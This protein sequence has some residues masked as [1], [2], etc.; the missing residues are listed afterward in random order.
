MTASNRKDGEPT[1]GRRLAARLLAEGRPARVL[2]PPSETAGWPPGT[3]IVVGDVARPG[4]TPAAFAGIERLFLAGALPATVREAVTLARAGGV[5]RIA[6]LSSHGPDMEIE[7]E[8]E[9][10]YW[11]AIEVVVE[12]SGAW[13][14][15]LQ[16]SPI[17]NQTLRAGYPRSRAS[18]AAAIRAGEVIR[19]PYPDSAVPFIDEDDLAAI[20]VAAL[21]EDGHAGQTLTVHGEPISLREQL[22]LIGQALGRDI[23]FA[24]Q[25]PEQAAE[26]ARRQGMAEQ[27]IEQWL[28][29]KATWAA[30]LDDPDY[31]RW[32]DLGITTVTRV[33]GRPPRSYA[34]WLADQVEVF[35]SGR[36]A[37]RGGRR[38]EAAG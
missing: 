11:L 22:R 3:E 9:S 24:E 6:V 21:F 18:L 34:D 20:A 15:H 5:A 10:W 26:H 28:A 4:E 7:F 19:E 36:P 13:W 35:G 30:T 2:A 37:N 12:R 27:E 38:V 17:M 14:T 32:L 23:P 31:R 33:L 8:P 29:A 1:F 16:P 25:T